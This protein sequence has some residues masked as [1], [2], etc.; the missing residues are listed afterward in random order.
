M[1]IPK[2]TEQ[3]SIGNG[4]IIF[5]GKNNKLILSEELKNINYS[6]FFSFDAINCSCEG[7]MITL[8]VIDDDI[9][10]DYVYLSSWNRPR[11]MPY[12]WSYRIRTAW[13]ILCGKIP[14]LDEILFKKSQLLV[15]RALIDKY[16]KILEEKKKMVRAKN[17][18]KNKKK[19]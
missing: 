11:F 5:F 7:H 14:F 13:Q 12:G 10:D 15:F 16:I 3:I 18:E 17:K 4:K 1:K 9:E 2:N 19:I 6:E 8:S